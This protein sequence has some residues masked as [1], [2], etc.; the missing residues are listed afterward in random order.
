MK[1]MIVDDHTDMRR[2]LKNLISFSDTELECV[3][4]K[5]GQEAIS[6]YLSHKPNWVLM[7]I[8]LKSTS[9][10][11]VT[12][13][14]YALDADAKVIIVTSYDTPTFRR[15]A[16]KLNVHGFVCKDKLSDLQQLLSSP[17][18]K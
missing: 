7:D 5:S 6:S 1:I 18:K 8:E 3:E 14:I 2:M 12:K 10:F 13:E 11:D 17:S 16:K 4:C 9:G 15:K